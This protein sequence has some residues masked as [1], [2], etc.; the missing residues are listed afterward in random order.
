M[1][2]SEINQILRNS[3]NN[4]E[5]MIMKNYLKTHLKKIILFST[6]VFW[7]AM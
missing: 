2:K 4:L 7:K 6:A 1:I 3:F 5:I